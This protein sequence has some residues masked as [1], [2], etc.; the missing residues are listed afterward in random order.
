MN[1]GQKTL[2]WSQCLS[3]SINISSFYLKLLKFSYLQFALSEF[4]FY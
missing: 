3:R 2:I 1:E 4:K